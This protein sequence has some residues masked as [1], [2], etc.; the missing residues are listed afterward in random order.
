M[1]QTSIARSLF[2]NKPTKKQILEICLKH[3]IIISDKNDRAILIS[4]GLGE[5]TYLDN[6]NNELE[7]PQTNEINKPKYKTMKLYQ[8]YMFELFSFWLDFS[9]QEEF[10]IH[11]I[12]QIASQR[13]EK[14]DQIKIREQGQKN[15]LTEPQIDAQISLFN[16][17]SSYPEINLY[18]FLD[19]LASTDE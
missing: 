12:I 14:F 2:P 5:V 16:T 7:K 9:R 10:K 8:D 3:Q 15:D 19:N 13:R 4:N 18:E 1:P 17:Q 11:E 6:E